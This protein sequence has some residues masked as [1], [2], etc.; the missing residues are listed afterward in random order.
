MKKRL[1]FIVMI[2]TMF[3]LVGCGKK[4]TQKEL[5]AHKWSVVFEETKDEEMILLAEFDENQMSLSIDANSI[6]TDS[7]NDFEELGTEMAKNILSAFNYKIDYKLD[8]K[9]IHLKSSDLDLDDDFEVK[10]EEDNIIFANQKTKVEMVLTPQEKQ[11]TKES[12]KKQEKELESQPSSSTND[13]SEKKSKE[14]TVKNASGELI[15]KELTTDKLK[16]KVTNVSFLDNIPS[17]QKE[18]YDSEGLAVIYYT[19][20]NIGTEPFESNMTV[21]NHLI[22]SEEDDISDDTLSP[23]FNLF[24]YEKFKKIDKD[25]RL[26]IKQGAQIK[27]AID[28]SFS[29]KDK[30]INIKLVKE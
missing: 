9:T 10:K 29:S 21:I 19:I 23:S 16:L 25:S 14:I 11:T 2:M 15:G 28:Y 3:V 24:E 30:N 22:V 7:N 6:E 27:G 5:M 18:I 8:G 13:S 17:S 4:V 20:E 26:N 1:A 12:T